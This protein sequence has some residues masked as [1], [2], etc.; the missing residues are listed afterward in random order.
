MAS[1]RV[2]VS[3]SALLELMQQYRIEAPK[4]WGSPS[5]SESRHRR[6]VPFVVIGTEQDRVFVGTLI[7]TEG[8]T[9]CRYEPKQRKT[10]LLVVVE[11]TDRDYIAR[12]AEIVGLSQPMSAGRLTLPG[13]K[14]KF[15][16]TLM[17][18]RALRV[19]R[20]VLPFMYGV[21]KREAQRAIDFFSP[22]GYREGRIAPDEIW[23]AIR[24]SRDAKSERYI[25]GPIQAD[26]S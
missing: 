24:D 26:S 18:L 22:T 14:P 23:G 5:A 11:M 17:G 13:H 9:T 8:A 6:P 2:G 7:G 16:R 20:E 3:K 10:A 15:R 21:K 12:F 1:N 19:L 25:H 4:S